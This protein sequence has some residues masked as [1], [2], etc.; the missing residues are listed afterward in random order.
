MGLLPPCVSTVSGA[1]CACTSAAAV[2]P[3]AA[4]LTV[5]RCSVPPCP[6]SASAGTCLLEDSRGSTRECRCSLFSHPRQ[7]EARSVAQVVRQA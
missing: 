7:A 6:V 4:L 1:P 5:A 3:G 2:M